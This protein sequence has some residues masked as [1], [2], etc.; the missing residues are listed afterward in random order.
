MLYTTNMKQIISDKDQKALADLRQSIDAADLRIIDLINQRTALAQDIGDIK[1]RNGL[2]VYAP[3]REQQVLQN[4][5]LYNTG[6][7]FPQAELKAV[8]RLL[9]QGSKKAQDTADKQ[10]GQ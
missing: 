2:P 4:I 6:G 1:R 7:I 8:F 5:E 3:G 10:L 9:M